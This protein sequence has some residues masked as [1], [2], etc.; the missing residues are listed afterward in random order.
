MWICDDDADYMQQPLD[1]G[2]GTKPP[3]YYVRRETGLFPAPLPQNSEIC[4]KIIQHYWFLGVFL[5]KVLQDNRLVDLPLSHAFLK[6][7]CH[8]EIRNNVN[9]RIGL[10][11]L[12]RDIED[13]VMTSSI[14]S[15]THNLFNPHF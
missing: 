13:D 4:D 3:G 14:I 15:G 10:V 1:L 12:R 6:L 5:A 8:G 9:E 11:G 2:E 7:M